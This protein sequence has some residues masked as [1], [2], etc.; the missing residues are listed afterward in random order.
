LLQLGC[1][2]FQDRDVSERPCNLYVPAREVA[3]FLS[4][5]VEAE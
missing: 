1:L 3:G 5:Q 2:L 4:L